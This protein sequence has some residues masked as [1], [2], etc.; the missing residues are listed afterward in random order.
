MTAHYAHTV[1]SSNNRHGVVQP[2]LLH[3]TFPRGTLTPELI[4]ALPATTSKVVSVLHDASHF[5]VLEIDVVNKKVV[6][7]DGLNRELNTWLHHVYTA[8]KRC[9]LCA[10]DVVPLAE[11][12]AVKKQVKRS[13][14]QQPKSLVEGMSLI[15]GSDTWRYTRG[16]FLTQTDGFNCGPIACAKILELFGVADYKNLCIEHEFN[17]LRKM[18]QEL[19]KQFLRASEQDVLVRVVERTQLRSSQLNDVVVPNPKV[20]AAAAASADAKIDLHQLCFCYSDAPSMVLVQM[21]CCKQTVH[22]VCLDRALSVNSKCPYCRAVIVDFVGI[23]ELQEVNRL[24]ILSVRIETEPLKSSLHQNGIPLA[25]AIAWMNQTHSAKMP[26]ENQ[27]AVNTAAVSDDSLQAAKM[28]PEYMA[29]ANTDAKM[30][31]ENM[32][33]V[34]T[35]TLN[36]NLGQLQEKNLDKTPLRQADVIRSDSQEQKRKAQLKQ[37]TRMMNQQG[38]D[39]TSRGAAPGAVVTVK[40]DHR[41]VSHVVGIVGIIYKIGPGGGARVATEYGLLSSG[42]KLGVWYIACDQ[43]K[44]QYAANSEA[45][46]TPELRGV[47]NAILGGMYNINNS[48]DKLTIQQAHQYVTQAISPCKKSKC[49][50]ANGSCRKGFCGCIKKNFKCTSACSCNGGCAANLNNGK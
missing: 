29:A 40:V 49:G 22:R 35:Q 31:P 33:A 44:V 7:F 26:P 19:W 38:R 39:V 48:P 11:L 14:D 37:A 36:N 32:S 12:D 4:K 2:T 6:I 43:Y 5:A 34:N 28:P 3:V 13:R 30:P 50:C 21:E 9:M 47:R 17:G 41:A 10:L 15:L 16:Q 42:P 24:D 27:V 8:F 18:V 23:Q 45:N 20:A 25:L 46:I 1:L